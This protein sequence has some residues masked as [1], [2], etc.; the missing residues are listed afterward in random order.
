MR[1]RKTLVILAMIAALALSIAASAVGAAPAGSPHAQ[2]GATATPAATG[3]AAAAPATTPTGAADEDGTGAGLNWPPGRAQSFDDTVAKPGGEL[4]GNPEVALVKVTDGLVDPITVSAPNDGSGRLFVVERVGRI[5]IVDEGGQLLPTPFLDITPTVK[6]DFLEQGLLGLAF[7]PDFEENGYFY[8][9]YT[10]WRTN[11]D[12]FIVRY[13]VSDDNPNVADPES[14]RVLLTFDQPYV[15]HNGGTIHFGPD[16]YLYIAT[17]DGGLAGDPYD[18]A[19]NRRE[20]LGK[21][22]RIDVSGIDELGVPYFVPEGRWEFGRTLY[23]DVARTQAQTN[24]YHPAQRPEI[25][26][27][28]LRNPWSFSFDPETGDIFVPD[29]GQNAWEEIN[30]IPAGAEGDLN[31]GWDYLEGAHC[32]PPDEECAPVGIL[33]VAE[34]ANNEEEGCSITGIGVYRGEEFADLDGIYFASDFCSGKV[35]GLAPADADALVK[36]DWTFSELLDTNLGVTGAGQGADGA[37]YVTSCNCSFGRSYNPFDNATGVLWRIMPAGA[38]PDDAETAPGTAVTPAAGTPAATGAPSATTTQAATAAATTAATAAATPAATAATTPAATS[39]ASP[40]TAATPTIQATAAVTTT[41]TPVAGGSG[42][43]ANTAMVSLSARDIAFDKNTITVPAG[44]L[45]EMEFTNH[46]AAPHNFALFRSSAAQE[47][48][49]R[50]EIITGPGA[51][52]TYRF[53]APSQPGTYY[54]HC[55]PHA[56][57]MFG[58][59]VVQ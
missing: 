31:F 53:Q 5:R 13:T 39:P 23:S 12:T 33:P 40:T 36:S 21:L 10:D 14:A 16:G 37:L 20:F 26:A 43:S 46:D 35:W 41:G 25:Y 19:Q 32:Y 29:V 57:T 54:F 4:P 11:G 9:N 59:F 45:V 2:T 44:A 1:L 56:P 50:G 22:L 49:F 15:N 42:S 58:D 3:T 28:G 17:G 38:V 6:I 48:I 34:Y 27:Y 55:D 47:V 8:I 18:N 24:Q 7:D 52:V 51:T 30:Y